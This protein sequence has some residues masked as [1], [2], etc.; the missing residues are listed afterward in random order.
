M[1]RFTTTVPRCKDF[2]NA[3]KQ[4]K[5][6]DVRGV[7]KDDFFRK[8][9]GNISPEDRQKLNEKVARQRRLR[10]ERKKHETRDIVPHTP[11]SISP[12]HEYVYGTHAV[13]AALTAKK[14]A[15]SKL[16]VHNPKEQTKQIIDLATAYGIGVTRVSDKREMK[17]LSS[18]GVHN[19][20]VVETKRLHFPALTLLGEVN[21]GSFTLV[22]ET[23]E[24]R[25]AVREGKQPIGVL[26]DGVTDPQNVGSIIRTAHFLGVDFLVVPE[27][28]S[29]RL[30]PV[31]AK[32][33]AGALDLL[34][35]YTV[36]NPAT[37]LLSAQ[38]NGWSV[39]STGTE[40]SKYIDL[41]ELPRL[42]ESPMLMVFGSEGDGVR[43]SIRHLS[44][45]VVGIPGHRGGIVDSLNVGV[46]AGF[47]L[48]K[49]VE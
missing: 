2:F 5:I 42:A 16:Y 4:R 32:A 40:S 12:G 22:S 15:F 29:A 7:S 38:K 45:H 41:E 44:D 25:E 33:A 46:A 8:K 28:D 3:P 48:G 30:G 19:G 34:P 43:S 17:R 9:Y 14:R 47:L 37:F 39:V 18:N 11:L 24:T 21:D 31:T 23:V 10:E 49:C 26:L 13:L 20:V 6:W 36:F 27:Q 35:I 1:R